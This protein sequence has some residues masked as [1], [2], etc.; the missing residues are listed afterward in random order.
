ML[1]V[2][3]LAVW[4]PTRG[5]ALA[6]LSFSASDGQILLLTGRNGCGTSTALAAIVADLPAGSR[7]QGAVV[8]DGVDISGAHP[9]DLDGIIATV[10]DVDPARSLRIGD[11]LH[12]EGPHHSSLESAA[13]R[14]PALLS[15]EQIANELGLDGHLNDRVA[16]ATR[17]LR[18]RAVLAAGLLAA[19]RLL[20]ADQPL[21]PMESPWRDAACRLLRAHADAGMTIVWAE[22]HL[23]HALAVADHVIEL[24]RPSNQVP[25]SRAVGTYPDEYRRENHARPRTAKPYPGEHTG[26]A[27]PAWQ[28]RPR[29][30][31]WTP[32]QQVATALG[33][34]G[35]GADDPNRLHD[36]LAP[37]LG[38]GLRQPPAHRDTGQLT[39]VLNDREK[40]LVRDDQMLR[41]ACAT[42][43][44]AA[45]AYD[46]FTAANAFTLAPTQPNRTL[47]DICRFQDR[48]SGRPKGSTWAQI[49]DAWP[50]L[51]GSDV[52]A[53][54][55]AGEQALVTAL[56]D[57]ESGTVV[58]LLDAGQ[59][60]D[61]WTRDRLLEHVAAQQRAGRTVVWIT[62]DAEDLPAAERVIVTDDG[63]IA[64]DGRA[65]AIADR[66]PY[67]PRL[68]VACAPRR[69][70]TAA[71]VIAGAEYLAT[72]EAS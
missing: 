22:H 26:L 52:L 23:I 45:I 38:Q 33:L 28:W 2:T 9:D 65:T 57:L 40:V 32:L 29:T 20:L 12:V 6:G 72:K 69:I 44:Q 47:A 37:V 4:Y 42:G 15:P 64:A 39:L 35:P 51:R 50:Q 61:G 5:L 21:A 27:H 63:Q 67:P 71:E 25:G 3:D 18:A 49:H 7:R 54:H 66:L 70:M 30:I 24:V 68:A 59:L 10:G 11:L 19:P 60:L 55:S 41:L 58:P 14:R 46:E 36:M 48:R 31:P 56:L 62:T 43:E 1:E 8:L 16:D 13:P 34:T 53:R 17:S